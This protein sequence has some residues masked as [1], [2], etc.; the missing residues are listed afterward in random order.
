MA[1]SVAAGGQHVCIQ[2]ERLGKLEAQA[3]RVEWEV[4]VGREGR[5]PLVVRIDRVERVAGKLVYVATA[6]LVAV[7]VQ[8]ALTVVKGLGGV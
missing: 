1:R 8:L 7:L 4:Y 6:V 2:A 3:E 5:Q